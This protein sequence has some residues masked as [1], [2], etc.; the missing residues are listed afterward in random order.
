MLIMIRKWKGGQCGWSGL[1]KGRREI[2]SEK[3]G[4][5]QIMLGYADQ[6]NVSDLKM[7]SH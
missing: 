5:G 3:E 6:L 7:E 2:R 4:D 1:S